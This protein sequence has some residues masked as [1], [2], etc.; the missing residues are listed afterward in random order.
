MIL[1]F[2]PRADWEAALETG[3]YRAPS[4]DT[5]GFIHCSTP[6]QVAIPANVL[7]RGRTDI[8]LLILDE[9]KLPEPI[10]WE[11]GDPPDPGGM[12]FPHLYAPIPVAAV[13][14]TREWLPE[15]DGSF[16]EPTDLPA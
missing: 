4:L 9:E 12:Q 3:T 10:V 16:R 5:Q 11:D 8:L 14:A 7:V 6:A 1:H 15:P 2:C 13:T